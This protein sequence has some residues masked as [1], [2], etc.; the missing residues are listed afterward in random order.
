VEPVTTAPP[1]LPR[2]KRAVPGKDSQFQVKLSGEWKDYD[3]QEGAILKKAYLVGHPNC[4]FHFRGQNYEYSFTTMA[5]KNLGTKK[6]REIRPPRGFKAPKN[7]LLPPGPMTVLTV[8]PGQPGT[9]IELPDPQNKGNTIQVN[10]PSGAKPGQKMAV[11]LPEP[12]STVQ[13]VQK[14]QK[15]HST[16]AKLAMGTAGIAAV[17]GLAVGGVILGDHLT[18]GTLGVSE[19]AADMAADAVDWA[20]GAVEDAPATV[21]AVAE[22][23]EGAAED[24][25][26]WIEG[27]TEDAGDWLG[28]AAEDTGDFIMSLF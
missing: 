26:E 5:Q 28:D 4:K 12:G 6:E 15:E 7:P 22:W 18:G 11:P 1:P 20:E 23:T 24:A 14:K 2:K 9:T 3:K 25:G 13:E 8:R 19:A 27:A 10:V 17:T 21:D 16:G